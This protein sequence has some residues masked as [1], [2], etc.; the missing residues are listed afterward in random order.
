VQPLAFYGRDRH[1]KFRL[2]LEAMPP[3]LIKKR[4]RKI[5]TLAV[6]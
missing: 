6:I 2:A 4:N 3:F 5:S 1:L